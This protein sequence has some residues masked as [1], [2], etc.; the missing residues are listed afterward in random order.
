MAKPPAVLANG[1]FKLGGIGGFI[2]AAL[3]LPQ[4]YL[5]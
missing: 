2:A 4:P 3:R 1:V 5:Q